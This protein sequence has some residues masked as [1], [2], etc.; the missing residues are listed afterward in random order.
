MSKTERLTGNENKLSVWNDND[1]DNDSDVW[2][3]DIRENENS[4]DNNV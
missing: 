1:N 3:D 4:L 2:Y